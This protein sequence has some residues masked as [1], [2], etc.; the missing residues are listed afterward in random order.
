MSSVPSLAV[1]SL[2]MLTP[3]LDRSDDA[4]EKLKALGVIPFKG[5]VS[6]FASSCS[7]S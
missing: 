2:H 4:A 3:N 5:D 1:L 7:A 6:I